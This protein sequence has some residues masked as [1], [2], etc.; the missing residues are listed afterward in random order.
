MSTRTNLRPQT[1]IPSPQGSPANSSSMAA[2]ITSAPTI[3]QSL[4]KFSYAVEWTGTSPV[5]T[6][7]VQVS[8]D[9]ALSG[10]GTVVNAGTWNV[11]TLTYNGSA[12][13]SVPVSGN[14][15]NGFIDVVNS[16][17]YAVRLVYTAG[18]GTGTIAAQ[19]NGKVS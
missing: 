1:V 3:L 8:N 18:S 13:T 5:G 10:A 4:T 2:N 11:M 15:G 7:A 12:V 17:A 19:F 16:A 9:Y 6:L 14:T